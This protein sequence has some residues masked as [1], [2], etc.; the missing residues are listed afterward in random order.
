MSTS[1]ERARTLA[2]SLRNGFK[3]VVLGTTSAAGVPDASVAP[4]V[5]GRDGE[6]FVYIS[7]LSAHTRNLTA[8]GRASLL[9]LEDESATAQLLAR[10]RLTFP[11]A[12]AP[13]A[14]E[15]ADFA[16]T[17]AALREKFGAAIDL[18]STMPDFQLFRLTLEPGRLVAGFGEAYTVDPLDWAS[19]DRVGPRQGLSGSMR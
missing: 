15:H 12:A 17:L 7:G 18:L 4:A 13:V 14:R 1:L 5:R 10:R 6:V 3:T 8:T 11:C 2:L 9:L 16:P 19:L